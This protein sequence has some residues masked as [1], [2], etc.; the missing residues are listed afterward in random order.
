MTEERKRVS[1]EWR[2]TLAFEGGETGRP[3]IPIDG[4]NTEAPG[5]MLLL[6]LAIASCTG[7]DVL[8][9]LEKMRLTVTALR[10]EV[11]G[12]RRAKAPRR[13]TAIE[14]TYHVAG[15]ELVEA[16]VQRAIDLSIEKYCSVLHSLAPDIEIASR[17]V[18]E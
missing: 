4:D 11:E 12:A 13:Y 18:L 6:L 2:G 16:K 1:L 17:L 14:L 3:W 9:I 7:A 10:V 8:I 5:P 15:Q